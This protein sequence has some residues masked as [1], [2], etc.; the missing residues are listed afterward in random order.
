VKLLLLILTFA[1]QAAV[2]QTPSPT[3]ETKQSAPAEKA[4][5]APVAAPAPVAEAAPA[6]PVEAESPRSNHLRITAGFSL[7]SKATFP[8]VKGTNAGT[9]ITG[10]AEMDIDSAIEI[11]AA[12]VHSPQYSW[13]F[14]AGFNY[15]TPRKI[16][17][18][19]D[20]IN[21]TTTTTTYSNSPEVQ[22]SVIEANAIYRWGAVYLPFGL[23]Y[24]IPTYNKAS[25]QAGEITVTGAVGGQAGV[26]FYPADNFTLEIESQVISLRGSEKIGTIDVDYGPGI[27]GVLKLTAGFL[28]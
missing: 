6:K 19:T 15:Q 28:F 4:A 27:M 12:F 22:I 23:N 14:S 7:G 8:S 10:S 9:P 24:S 21:G 20:T 26:G 13:G 18:E 17:S 5:L 11:G 25:G 2:A 1:G 16:K 3:Q